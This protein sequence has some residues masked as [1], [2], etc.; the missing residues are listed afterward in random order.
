MIKLKALIKETGEMFEPVQIDLRDGMVG[1][2]HPSG[3]WFD[4]GTYILMI[5]IEIDGVTYF[6]NDVFRDVG[7]YYYLCSGIGG[8][9][10]NSI[11]CAMPINVGNIQSLENVGHLWTPENQRLTKEF[12]PH[13]YSCFQDLGRFSE[14]TK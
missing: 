3:E 13:V 14:V 9:I 1:I 7:C 2:Q 6:E 5:G 4:S 10:L 8:W 11:N 12:N